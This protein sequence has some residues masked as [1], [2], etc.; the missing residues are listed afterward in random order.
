MLDVSKVDVW[1]ATIEDRPGGLTEK[2][3]ALAKA[4][5]NLEFILA[6]RMHEEPGKGVVF[7]TPLRDDRQL[8]A[9][10]A[11]GFRKTRSLHSLRMEG[12]D[13]PG[14]GYRV[15][16]AMAGEG[17]SLRGLSVTTTNGQVVMYLAFDSQLDADRAAV[18]LENAL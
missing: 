5:A 10:S 15:S 1:A 4:G 6:R 18:R 11:A 7:V 3:E 9:A 16:Q 12:P 8:Q 17:I 13:E 14:L 2:L